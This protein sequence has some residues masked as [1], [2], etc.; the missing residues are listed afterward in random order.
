M[1]QVTLQSTHHQFNCTADQTVLEAALAAHLVLPHSCRSGTCGSCKAHIIEGTVDYGEHQPDTLTD[2]EKAEG[3]AL[4][5]RAKPT[6]DALVVK[7]IG[8]IRQASE[9]PVRKLPCRIEQFEKPAPDVAVLQLKLPN[10]D[11]LDFWAGQYIDILLKDGRRRSF[12]LANTPKNGDVLELHIRHVPGGYFTDTVFSTFKGKEILRFEGPLGGFT[13]NEES[14]KPIICVA[15]GT[16]FAPIQ[17]IIED[18]L[19][20]QLTRPI[21]LYWGVRSLVDLYRAERASAWQQAHS[22]IT[23]IPVLSEPK[24]EDQWTGRTGFVHEAVLQD[25]RDLSG[26]EVYACGSP[27]MVDAARRDFIELA[28]LHE[29]AFFADS[30]DLAAPTETIPA[31]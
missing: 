1:S 11:R 10:N 2:A 8:G 7:V 29:E 4:L 17:S 9:K 26:Y 18:S 16:G 19:D 6:S 21:V 12:S 25:F 24:V 22:H 20:K 14:D 3:L 31:L 15:G 28:H 30:F 27:L 5:C 23:F 13:L